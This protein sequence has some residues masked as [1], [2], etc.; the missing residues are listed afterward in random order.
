[1][2]LQ[3]NKLTNGNIYIDGQNFFGTI[4]EFQLPDVKAVFAEHK[5]LGM[6]G[7]IELP[8]GIDKVEARLRFNAPYVEAMK[9]K[10]N[11]F[12]VRQMQFRGNLQTYQGQQLVAETPYKVTIAA[13]FKNMPAGNM[14]QHD[15]VEME[16]M[17]NVTYIKVD[18][19]TEN[20]M[21]FDA[22]NNIYIVDGVDLLQQYRSNLGL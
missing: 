9:M 14:K 17:L 6:V 19:G 10:A 8:S 16:T 15:N 1:M 11:P 22:L 20:I 13:S 4:E 3:V 7:K 21:E 2:A 18:I 12:V 5:A